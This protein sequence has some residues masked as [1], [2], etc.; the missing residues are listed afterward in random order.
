MRAFLQL[1]EG[2]KHMGWSLEEKGV[3]FLFVL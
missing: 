3:D 1:D 2:D